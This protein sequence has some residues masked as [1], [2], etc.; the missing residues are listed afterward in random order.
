MCVCSLGQEFS[1]KRT[2]EM[3]WWVNILFS[4]DFYVVKDYNEK[5]A[6]DVSDKTPSSLCLLSDTY[7]DYFI[8]FSLFNFEA[9]FKEIRKWIGF[10]TEH[11]LQLFNGE[12]Y[13]FPCLTYLL[14]K[15]A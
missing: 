15:A 2:Q 14:K 13:D 11:I 10:T 12:I 5:I 3:C 4:R 7:Y 1:M 8:Q 9:I 6:S